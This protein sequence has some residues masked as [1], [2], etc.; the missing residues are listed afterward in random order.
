[1]FHSDAVS[2][3]WRVLLCLALT[4]LPSIAVCTWAIRRGVDNPIWLSL[5]ALAQIGVSGYLAFWLWFAVPALGWTFSLL[6]PIASLIFLAVTLRRIDPPGRRLLFSLLVPIALTGVSTLVVL[7]A[8]FLYGGFDHPLQTASIRFSDPLPLDNHIPYDFA[9]ALEKHVYKPRFGDWLSSDRPPLQTGIYL[10][11]LCYLRGPKA[12]EVLSALLESLW[13][14]ALYILL[15][16]FQVPSKVIPLVLA[17]SLFSGFVFLNTLFVWPKLLAA[18]YLLAFGAVFLSPKLLNGNHRLLKAAIGGILLALALLSHG[19]S[20][21]SALG[22]ACALPLLQFRVAF[23]TRTIAAM[24]A[25]FSLYLPWMLYQKLYDLPGDCLMKWYLAGMIPP[26][27]LSSERAIAGAYR[28]APAA[29]IAANK[30]SNFETVYD[31][32]VAYWT[33]VGSLFSEAFPPRSSS[34]TAAMG[35]A[36]GLRASLFFS[37]VPSLGFLMFGPCALLSGLRR[38]NRSAEWKSAVALIFACVSRWLAGACL[39]L[40]LTQP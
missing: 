34:H 29:Q 5:I 40:A 4:F 32:P 39:C 37:F 33:V 25:C 23:S 10:S 19:G 6:L 9:K 20:I 31:H 3:F 16:A 13:I 11:E 38:R 17:T 26:N 35:T 2:I 12:Y 24:L 28:D 7:S 21:F 18:A 14:Y 30:L 27:K 15:V 8:G 22:V 36:G 1:M